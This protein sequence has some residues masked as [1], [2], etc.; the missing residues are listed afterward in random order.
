MSEVQGQPSEQ[1][2]PTSPTP[3]PAGS[4]QP[5][6]VAQYELGDDA[7]AG[8]APAPAGESAAATAAAPPSEPI[9]APAPSSGP[10]RGPDGRFVPKASDLLVR[11]AKSLGLSDAEIAE[12]D[13]ADLRAAVQALS[14]ERLLA[15]HARAIEAAGPARGQ[16]P[17]PSPAAP[18]ADDLGL[19]DE[20]WHPD[21]LRVVRQLH[22]QNQELRAQVAE[23]GGWAQRQQQEAVHEQIDRW[24]AKNESR[25]GKGSRHDLGKDNP[26]LLR[27]KALLSLAEH[28]P[29]GALEQ[30]LAQAEAILYPAAKPEPKPQGPS[31]AEL[32]W[33]Q[34]ALARPTHRS[35]AAEP[36]GTE[37]AVAGVQ[38]YL[39]ENGLNQTPAAADDFPE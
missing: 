1:P 34:G 9:P 13:P 36:R 14:S 11:Q 12:A 37:R 23:I 3:A 29:P 16:E 18:P 38:S 20:D 21:L 7:P 8:P 28:M 4:A 10:P 35:G 5:S 33:S 22:R 26:D 31:P 15:A 24:F 19:K 27:R 25:Y 30:R 39:R 17:P 6:L 2:V 32:A